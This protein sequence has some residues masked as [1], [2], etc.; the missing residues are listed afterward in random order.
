V[1][2]IAIVA[3]V[4]N[5][6]GLGAGSWGMGRAGLLVTGILMGMIHWLSNNHPN[7]QQPIHSL[8]STSKL[9]FLSHERTPW[10]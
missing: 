8:L 7:P 4:I 5:L 3:A 9:G 1:D 6:L 10:V 2:S